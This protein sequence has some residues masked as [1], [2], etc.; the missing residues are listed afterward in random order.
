MGADELHPCPLALV[1]HLLGLLERDGH[2][3]L[4]QH[5]LPVAG[6]GDGVL[7]VEPVGGGD[8]HRVD[9]RVLADLVHGRVDLRV[10]EPLLEPLP[11]EGDD[12]AARGQ[13]D[14]LRLL[15]GGPDD[16]QA[17]HADADDADVDLSSSFL[18]D[19]AHHLRFVRSEL[20]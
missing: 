20:G 2:R 16:L 15:D 1:D 14:G 19:H 9:V 13:V 18:N 10:G 12:V 3:L 6:G 17:P 7:G 4:D 5:V 11:R 8:V